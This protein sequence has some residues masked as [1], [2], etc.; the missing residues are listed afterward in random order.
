MMYDE[1]IK[2]LRAQAEA[3][4]FYVGEEMLYSQAA[5]AIEELSKRVPSVPHGRL[6]DA[7]ALEEHDGWLRNSMYFAQ[8]SGHTHI[9]FVYANDIIQAPTVIPAEPY[10]E[11][12]E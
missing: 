7:D 2:R 11:K 10:K 9:Q 3:E 12:G 4:R 5:N 6:I 1:L 8:E